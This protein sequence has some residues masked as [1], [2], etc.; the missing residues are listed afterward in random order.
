MGNAHD[1]FNP[2]ETSQAHP[3]EL[4][5]CPRCGRQH[6]RLAANP[7]EEIASQAMKAVD[8]LRTPDAS[9][10]AVANTVRQSI[11][12]VI[13]AQ[14]GKIDRYALALMMIREGC[15]DVRHFAGETLRGWRCPAKPTADPPQDCN[16]PVCGC[17]PIANKVIEALEESGALIAEER[18]TK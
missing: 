5:E 7:P 6:P 10:R 15:A 2:A 17:D 11:A 16:W 14:K 18:G 9:L 8:A 12:D 1:M 4:C 3:R 13:E